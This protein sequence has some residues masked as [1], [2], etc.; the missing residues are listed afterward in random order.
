MKK[1][2]FLLLIAFV[3]SC[4]K[5]KSTFSEE[6]IGEWEWTHSTY[7][8]SIENSGGSI[9]DYFYTLDSENMNYT[10]SIKVY[11]TG[12]IKLYKDDVHYY[13]FSAYSDNL[14]NIKLQIDTNNLNEI[15]VFPGFPVSTF[16]NVNNNEFAISPENVG[17]FSFSSYPIVVNKFV[18]K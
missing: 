16:R 10:A 1:L 13:T 3:V 15:L 6:L 18:K 17:D 4:S 11:K 7:E 14:L 2:F 12:R 9:S 8:Y 5:E